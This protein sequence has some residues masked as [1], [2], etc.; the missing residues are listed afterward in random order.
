MNLKRQPFRS[1]KLLDSAR[2]EDCT[3]QIPGVCNHNPE[4]TV[5]AHSNKGYHGKGMGQK[6]DDCFIAY[7]CSECHAALDGQR[8][9]DSYL[10]AEYAFDRARD[11]TLRRMLDKGVLKVG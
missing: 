2:G 6:A 10:A 4:T 3:M 1:R 8:G 11:K 5:A 9:A 7:L